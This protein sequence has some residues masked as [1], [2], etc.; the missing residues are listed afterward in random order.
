LFVGR[1]IERNS[2]G[3]GA[4][5]IAEAGRLLM[6]LAMI[7]IRAGVWLERRNK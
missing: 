5:R 2:P 7:Q 4:M 1:L 3:D 6:A